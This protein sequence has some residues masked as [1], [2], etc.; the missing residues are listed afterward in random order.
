MNTTAPPALPATLA[1]AH[2]RIL[3]LEQELARQRAAVAAEAEQRAF[4]QDIL[5]EL[6]VDVAVFNE[7]HRYR[8]LNPQAIRNPE[9]RA[10]I[11]GKDDFEYCAYRGFDPSRAVG[12]RAGF[13]QALAERRELAWEESLPQPDGSTRH[14]LRRYLPVYEAGGTL[15]FVFGYGLEITDRVLAEQEAHQARQVAEKA[16]LARTTFLATMSHE[17]RTPLNG[18]LGMALLLAKTALTPEQR[19]HVGIIHSSGQH[20][21][22]VINDV[23]DVAKITSGKLELERVPFNLVESVARAVAPLAEQAR[24]RHLAFHTEW[25]GL[26]KAEAWVLG[27]P[28]RLNQ[29][30]LNLLSNALKFTPAGGSVMLRCTRPTCVMDGLVV[31]FQ[32]SDTGIGIP[33][34]KLEYVFES[35]AQASAETT[36]QFGGTGLGLSISRALVAQ[37]G[38]QLTVAS[39]PGQGSTF[40]FTLALLTATAPA[41]EAPAQLHEGSLDGLRFLLVEDNDI[42][43]VIARRLVQSWGGLVDEAPSGVVALDLFERHRYDIVLMDIQLPDLS[44]VEITHQLRQHPD[45]QRART[46]ILALTANAY[47]SD[48]QQYLAAGMNDCLSKPFDENVLWS[49]LMA[50]RPASPLPE[51]L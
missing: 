39:C 45:A 48:M 40:A 13:E 6:P 38:G 24:Q 14:F 1:E 19:E 16:A 15:K 51:K 31:E 41:A 12:R 9:I 28:F 35:F 44:G 20:L 46:A 4:Y 11:V 26:D 25:L 42:N 29:I 18:V 33:A 21:L 34:D 17:I 36:R 3:E 22:G 47:K 23:L 8:F 27:D 2:A 50:L 30:L 32:V 49:K 7:A 10:W 5:F 37:L 43:R